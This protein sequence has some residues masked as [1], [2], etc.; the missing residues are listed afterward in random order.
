MLQLDPTHRPSIP[1][2]LAHPWMQGEVPTKEQIL[3]EFRVRDSKVKGFMEAEKKKKEAEKLQRVEN[4]RKTN[5]SGAVKGDNM[6]QLDQ[7]DNGEVLQPTKVLEQYEHVYCQNTQFFSSYNP[8]MIEL[9]LVEHLRNDVK[10]EPIVNPNKYKV[11]FTLTSQDQGGQQIETTICVRI[12]K[13]DDKVVCVEFQKLAGNQTRFFDHYLEL[14][15]K[16]LAFANDQLVEMQPTDN[17]NVLD[18]E[19]L[20]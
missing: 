16:V 20:A 4:F 9:A 11:K 10:T 17:L 19:V 15:D 13:V 5:R 8:D 14:K 12:S 7:G 2:I 1:D 18:A 3:K 6:A